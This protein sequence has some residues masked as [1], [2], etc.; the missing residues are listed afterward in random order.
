MN[1]ASLAWRSCLLFVPGHR[2]D[3][4]EKARKASPEGV[5]LDLEDAVPAGEKGAA[6]AAVIDYLATRSDGSAVHVRINGAS[7][8]AGLDDLAALADGR[9]PADG[10]VLPKVESARDIEIVRQLD[11]RPARALMAAVESAAGIDNAR[12]IAAAL[13][14]GDALVFGGAELAADLGAAFAWEP[15]LAARCA[16]VRAAAAARLPAFDVPFLKIDAPEALAE[17]ARRVRDLGFSGKLAIHP[18]QVGPIRAAF[19]PTPDEVDRAR[20]IVAAIEAAGGGVATVDGRMIDAPV[21]GSARRALARVQ[22][23]S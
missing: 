19:S 23:R 9:L 8:R 11:P 15:L 17:E 10:L 13:G 14:E 16:L 6:R 1:G 22:A 7:T 12:A 21:A 2:P 3:R 18:A 4:F 20:R 5:V